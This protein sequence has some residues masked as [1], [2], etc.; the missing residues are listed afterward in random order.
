MFFVV[1]KKAKPTEKSL[2]RVRKGDFSL[3]LEVTMEGE[4]K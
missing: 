3:T 1:S 4:N 2:S